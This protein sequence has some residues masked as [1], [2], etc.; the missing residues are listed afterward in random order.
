MSMGALERGSAD[1]RPLRY[2]FNPFTTEVYLSFPAT[3]LFEA[4]RSSD[5]EELILGN[6]GTSGEIC[7]LRVYE[8]DTRKPICFTANCSGT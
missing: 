8:R 5:G 6:R 4:Q 2:D 1:H 3:F 7:R